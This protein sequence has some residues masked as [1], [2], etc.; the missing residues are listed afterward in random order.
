MKKQFIGLLTG[1]VVLSTAVTGCGGEKAPEQGTQGAD[2]KTVVVGATPV[3]HVEILKEVQ[4]L[5][6]KKG[7][8]LVIKDFADYTII[9]KALD[10]KEVDANFFQHQPYLDDSNQ[11]NGYDLIATAKV[12]IE[13]LGIYSK[14]VKT[15]A[16]LKENATIAI[17]NDAT[18]G[19]RALQLLAK[20]G[21]F[22]LKDGVGVAATKL[23]IVENPKKIKIQELDAAVVA[24]TLEDVDLAV[25]NG[26]YALDAKLVPSKDAI[27]LESGDNNPFANILVVRKGD[28]NREEI[29]ALGEALNSPEIKTF[30]EQK[31][32]GSVL[33]AF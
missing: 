12:H 18:N 23:D 16:E 21:L 17:P 5:L 14:K 29:K 30:I 24:R 7:I 31:Y 28:E 32:Q 2:E 22:T 3:P 25:I 20:A 27:Q 8:K 6:A 11:K 26:N 33:A 1:L 19:G 15:L 10:E 4:P 13:P 9:N